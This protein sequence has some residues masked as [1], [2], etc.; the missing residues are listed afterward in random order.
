MAR[1]DI[2]ASR[3]FWVKALGLGLLLPASGL[4]AV[5]T[6]FAGEQRFSAISVD[7]KPLADKGLSGYAARITKVAQPLVA[8]VFADRL[9]P[10]TPSAP[11]LVIRI[12][13]IQLGSSER[14]RMPF[15]IGSSNDLDWI[16]GAGV[17]TDA[18]GKVLHVEPI[19]TSAQAFGGSTADILAIEALRTQHLIT[20]LAQWIHQAV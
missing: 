20:V 13:S 15:S 12:D 8:E 10:N 19:E 11:R 1:R 6:A 7:T 18:H 2:S 17:V 5:Q 16:S 14:Q 4:A 9:T 3:R